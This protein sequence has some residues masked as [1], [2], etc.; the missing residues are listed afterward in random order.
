MSTIMVIRPD[1]KDPTPAQAAAGNY[2]KRK[3]VWQGLTISIENEAGSMRRGVAPD[4]SHWQRRMLF[5]YGYINRTMGVDGDQVDVYL[6]PY[7]DAPH[8]YVVH[9]RRYGDWKAYDEDKCM[10]GFDCE[11]SAKAAF[12]AC[13][14]DPRFLGPI[15]TLTVDEFRAKVLATK[16]APNM[17]KALLF[18][19]AEVA[20]HFRHLPHRT[21]PV[22]G[23]IR[24]GKVHHHP[25]QPSL[26]STTVPDN[27]APDP[28]RTPPVNHADKFYVTMVRKGT[29]V[30]Y[31]AGPFDTNDEAVGYIEQAKKTAMEIDPFAHFDA[32]GTA[33]RT[34]EKHPPGVLNRR[35]GLTPPAS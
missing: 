11:D 21:V 35:L 20:A 6:G 16:D 18:V 32:F 10:V 28:G 4:G 30:A 13:Y 17:V 7:P 33:K 3:V 25:E 29:G 5:P 12:L 8:V 15:T 26:F 1:A 24:P 22:R 19:K 23:Y 34:A 27:A 2:A 14:D 9:Q 31:L